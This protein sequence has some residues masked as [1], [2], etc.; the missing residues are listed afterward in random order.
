M[1][2]KRESSYPFSSRCTSASSYLPP[3]RSPWTITVNDVL[4]AK[5]PFS[6][7]FTKN[8]LAFFCNP[9]EQRPKIMVL[10]VTM[11]GSNPLR[12]RL[13]KRS[14][15]PSSLPL[16]HNPSRM[17]SYIVI[18]LRSNLRISILCKKSNASSMCPPLHSPSNITE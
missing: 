11:L 8:S 15:A 16:L 6:S 12:R 13:L 3:K 7:I 5:Q 18:C 1:R 10:Y 9:C 2:M 4:F 17:M 14:Q